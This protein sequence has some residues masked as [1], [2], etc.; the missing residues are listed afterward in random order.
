M[1]SQ[2][3]NRLRSNSLNINDEIQEGSITNNSNPIGYS[4]NKDYDESIYFQHH[5]DFFRRFN[6]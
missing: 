3:K 1:E 6:A 5:F 2:T 4:I